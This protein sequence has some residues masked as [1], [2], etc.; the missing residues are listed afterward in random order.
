MQKP[1]SKYILITGVSTGIGYGAAK[2]LIRNGFEVFGSVRKA[3]DG[4]R[5]QK[6]LGDKFTPLVFDVTDRKAIASAV[7]AIEKTPAAAGLGGLI[8]NAG[9]AVGGPLLHLPIEEVRFNFEVNVIGLLQVTQAFLPLL[10]AR[11]DHPNSPGRILNISSVGGKMSAP[12]I[13]PYAGTKHAVEGIS[14]SMRRELLL[15][16][17]DVVIIGPGSV[18]TPIWD[19]G[20]DT[21]PYAG[22][23]YGESL[24]KFADYITEEGRKGFSIDEIGS[25]IASIYMKK[26]PKTR[27]ALVPGK[28]KNWTLPRILP[29]RWIDRMIGKGIGL[30]K[31]T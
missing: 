30:I 14:H 18:N 31:K 12:F 3:A 27:Y 7:S 4:D 6:E 13:G 26:K 19:K 5:V 15:Y 9:I 21:S 11:K 23:E 24:R 8:N 2:H 20:T 1:E 25:Q 22:T 16:G 10:G 17:I 28:F 29:D